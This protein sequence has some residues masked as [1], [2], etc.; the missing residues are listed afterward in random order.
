[1]AVIKANRNM[2][3]QSSYITA[4]IA[5]VC[6]CTFY[7]SHEL[8]QCLEVVEV[9]SHFD[10][11]IVSWYMIAIK[12]LHFIIN[13]LMPFINGVLVIQPDQ[14]LSTLF[15]YDEFTLGNAVIKRISWVYAL[16]T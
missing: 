4:N 6:V 11:T 7:V 15:N 3:P 9:Q 16:R 5:I 1:M 10:L 14:N 2:A 12:C 13:R 8:H